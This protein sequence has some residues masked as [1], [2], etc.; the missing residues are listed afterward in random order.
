MKRTNGALFAKEKKLAEAGEAT[1]S[2]A[3]EREVQE[4]LGKWKV[5]NYVR[6]G[7]AGLGALAGLVAL[8]EG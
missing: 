7:L 1:A 3:E 8:V 2:E 4:L 5:L 6:A